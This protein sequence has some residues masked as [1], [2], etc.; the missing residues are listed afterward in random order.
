MGPE[1][2]ADAI[3]ADHQPPPVDGAFSHERHHMMHPADV[4]SGVDVGREVPRGKSDDY[5]LRSKIGKGEIHGTAGWYVPE[6]SV[7]P[8]PAHAAGPVALPAPAVPLRDADRTEARLLRL[9]LS[10]SR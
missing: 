1:V 8:D 5:G 4:E 6:H 9:G 7:L 3:G 2:I 10:G